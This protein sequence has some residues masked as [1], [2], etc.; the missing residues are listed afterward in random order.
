[1]CFSE[2]GT[3]S[4]GAGG[5]K[6]FYNFESLNFPPNH[7]ARDTQDT[8]V[9]ADQETKP[10]ARAAADAT[11]T[12]PVQIR[13]MLEQDP[14]LRLVIRERCIAMMR[15]RYTLAGVSQVEGLCVGT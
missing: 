14:P 8:L 13:S 11:H 7:P 3:P 5:R 1:M 2:W 15:R 6:R 9:V 10:A 12:S 4:T